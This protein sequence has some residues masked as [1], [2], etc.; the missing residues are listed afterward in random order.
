M[1]KYKIG[2]EKETIMKSV[3]WSLVIFVVIMLAYWI[4]LFEL[5]AID[6]AIYF[7]IGLVVVV[8]LIGL[9]VLGNP[10]KNRVKAKEDKD[11]E[12]EL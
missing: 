10:V 12:T 8:F 1:V 9:F 2:Q 4:G 5:F 11:D 6:G 7:A 3:F